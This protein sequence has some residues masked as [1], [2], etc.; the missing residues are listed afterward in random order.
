M[1]VREQVVKESLGRE[2]NPP[3]WHNFV[4]KS[5][6]QTLQGCPRLTYLA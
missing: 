5:R 6:F 2:G 4:A 3:K 1:A